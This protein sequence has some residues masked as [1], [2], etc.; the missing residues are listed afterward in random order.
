[1][2]LTT[3]NKRYIGTSLDAKPSLVED[4]VGATFY[5][6]DT[7]R[8]F[9]FFDN[10]WTRNDSSTDVIEVLA[11]LKNMASEL[12]EINIHL[13]AITEMEDVQ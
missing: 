12:R 7:K 13:R 5:E 10:A 3:N 6:T 11:L 8:T 2:L 1:M 9:V 4:D